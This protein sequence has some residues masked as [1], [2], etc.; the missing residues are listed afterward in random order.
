MLLEGAAEHSYDADAKKFNFSS[1]PL[2]AT[3]NRD[4]GLLIKSFYAKNR[5]LADTE[6]DAFLVEITS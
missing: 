5:M 6:D 1:K 4:A 2:K 3:H